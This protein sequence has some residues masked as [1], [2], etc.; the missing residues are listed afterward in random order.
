MDE[1]ERSLT[2]RLRQESGGTAAFDRLLATGDHDELGL[3]GLPDATVR[4]ACAVHSIL[5]GGD[6][7]ILI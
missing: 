7:S 6:H 3:P 1:E 2:E 5:D 4:L